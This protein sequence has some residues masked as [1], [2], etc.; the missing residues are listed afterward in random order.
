MFAWDEGLGAEPSTIDSR[1]LRRSLGSFPT[2]IC[3]VTTQAADGKRE[4]MT[5]N[6]FASVSL[7]PPLVSWGVRDEARSADVF[8]ANKRFAINVL[9]VEHH[10]LANHFARPSADKFAAFEQHF[11][12]EPGGSPVLVDALVSY[13]CSMYSQHRE[14]DHIIL[15]GRVDAF[16]S[17]EGAPLVFYAG[18]IGSLGEHAAR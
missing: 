2:G 1:L 10:A 8:L 14:G 13:E 3:L 12:C 5:I 7:A 15:I 9:A 17:R 16:H 6:S 11:R 4:G 18:Q